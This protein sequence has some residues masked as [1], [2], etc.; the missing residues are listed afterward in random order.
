MHSGYVM[1]YSTAKEWRQYNADRFF[2]ALPPV[3]F[4]KNSRQETIYLTFVS[5]CFKL[6]IA[7]FFRIPVNP[8]CPIS[9]LRH[10]GRE[11]LLPRQRESEP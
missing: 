2:R 1:D 9:A 10:T 8:Q 11:R 7:Y 5:P 3:I 6:K 4:H